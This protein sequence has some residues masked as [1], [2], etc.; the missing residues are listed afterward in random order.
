[1]PTALRNAAAAAALQ[2]TRHGAGDA[3]PDRAEVL[4][5]LDARGERLA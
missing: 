2:V 3:M 1:V 4:D 5:F